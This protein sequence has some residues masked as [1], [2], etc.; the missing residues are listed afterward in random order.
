MLFFLFGCWFK[1]IPGTL[2]YVLYNVWAVILIFWTILNALG[3]FDCIINKRAKKTA[4][5]LTDDMATRWTLLSLMAVI[6]FMWCEEYW[7][8]LCFMCT[9]VPFLMFHLYEKDKLKKKKK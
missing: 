8:T 5:T 2:P 4:K 7:I 1:Y 9:S 3:V 6:S